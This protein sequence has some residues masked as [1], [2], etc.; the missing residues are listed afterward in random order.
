MSQERAEFI[1]PKAFETLEELSGILD[2]PLE[3]YG[4]LL[5]EGINPTQRIALLKEL[6]VNQKKFEMAFQA[7]QEAN[8]PDNETATNVLQKLA[9]KIRY[10][11]MLA[12]GSLLKSEVDLKRATL[13]IA[14]IDLSVAA[15]QGQ[16]LTTKHMQV[17]ESKADLVFTLVNQAATQEAF[18]A[19]VKS[20]EAKESLNP[21]DNKTSKQVSAVLEDTKKLVGKIH[22]DEERRADEITT[23][24]KREAKDQREEEKNAAALKAKFSEDLQDLGQDKIVKE[25]GT[26]CK[27]LRGNPKSTNNE[28]AVFTAME[29]LSSGLAAMSAKMPNCLI[30]QEQVQIEGIIK[31][32]NNKTRSLKQLE[33]TVIRF[34]NSKAPILASIQETSPTGHSIAEIYPAL[35]K[36]LKSLNVNS[37]KEC[38][39]AIT[40]LKMQ[41]EVLNNRIA[42]MSEGNANPEEVKKLIIL[43]NSLNDLEMIA[44]NANEARQAHEALS[45]IISKHHITEDSKKKPAG[46]LDLDSPWT[47]CT[48]AGSQSAVRTVALNAID[49]KMN[50]QDNTPMYDLIE[51]RHATEIEKELLPA[52]LNSV[53]QETLKS[54]NIAWE[55]GVGKS[56]KNE[57]VSKLCR[58]LLEK[59]K[60]HPE[61]GQ[62]NFNQKQDQPDFG[63]FRDTPT[64]ASFVNKMNS[65]CDINNLDESGG[66]LKP[67]VKAR[68]IREMASEFSAFM[69][70]CGFDANHLNTHFE[71]Y[72]SEIEKRIINSAQSGKPIAQFNDFEIVGKGSISERVAQENRAEM[73]ELALDQ[74]KPTEVQKII[75]ELLSDPNFL[76]MDPQIAALIREQGVE[77]LHEAIR[78]H[79]NLDQNVVERLEYKIELAWAAKGSL[80]VQAATQAARENF[81]INTVYPALKRAVVHRFSEKVL[82]EAGLC[83]HLSPDQSGVNRMCLLMSSE[84]S[85]AS[86]ALVASTTQELAQRH[87]AAAEVKQVKTAPLDLSNV[88]RQRSQSNPQPP[89]TRLKEEA[90]VVMERGPETAQNEVQMPHQAELGT[91]PAKLRTQT[92]ELR[93][94]TR[95]RAR[96]VAAP[97]PRATRMPTQAPPEPPGPP[98]LPAATWARPKQGPGPKETQETAQSPQ[99]DDTHG[100]TDNTTKKF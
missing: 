87:S 56:G 13:Q 76:A 37:N 94:E 95:P 64:T 21:S 65:F 6:A 92:A 20:T 71:A 58:A 22:K 48:L 19:M 70:Q 42:K 60:A 24:S 61:L 82:K 89:S 2:I 33:N 99:K 14:H 17:V 62:F 96:S 23:L 9:V 3:K 53:R 4:V 50:A 69:I 84:I 100:H 85:T 30:D 1:L 5:N 32:D 27:K 10:C 80:A 31:G 12:K 59:I 78:D 8:A 15:R 72:C 55:D 26:L 79:F 47:T 54:F 35:V 73:I 43:R 75:N 40:F 67:E 11:D 29:E 97:G 39:R 90:K 98:Q 86:A 57:P 91:P 74:L 34:E 46:I 83:T 45:E 28:H 93:T 7:I 18:N 36:Q 88:T 68:F 52:F 44:H 51:L 63:K 81:D 77:L 16:P 41:R 49:S 25:V 66:H 38:L